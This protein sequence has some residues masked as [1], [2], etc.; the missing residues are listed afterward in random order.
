MKRLNLIKRLSSTTWGS[1]KNTLKGL[2]LGYA[3]AVFD[4]NIVLQNICSNATKTSLDSIQ[5]HVLRFIS[6]GMKSS[7]TAACE[8]HTHIEPLEIRKKRA[9]LELYERSKR[10]ERDHPNIVLVDKWKSNQRLK[11]TQSVLD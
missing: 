2:Y 11:H 3:R 1:D 7:P 9:A 5:N 4:Y 8:I 10:L 6:D